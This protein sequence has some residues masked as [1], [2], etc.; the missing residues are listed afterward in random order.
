MGGWAALATAT[1]PCEPPN[2]VKYAEC[3]EH[4]PTNE[5]LFLEDGEDE[6][7]FVVFDCLEVIG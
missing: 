2:L 5:V 3:Y 1:H 7:D 6:P 4:I